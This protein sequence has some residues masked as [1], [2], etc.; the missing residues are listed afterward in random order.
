MNVSTTQRM[1][2]ETDK[3]TEKT[4]KETNIN[5]TYHEKKRTKSLVPKKPEIDPTS[6]FTS[7]NKRI[8]E[9]LKKVPWKYRAKVASY[10]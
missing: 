4:K 7:T 8:K 1:T 3:N 6:S 2:T 10:I 9:S 5:V